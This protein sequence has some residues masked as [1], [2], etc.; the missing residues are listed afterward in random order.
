[1]NTGGNK[2]FKILLYS[3]N[4]NRKTAGK[5]QG[6]KEK[7][8]FH[9]NMKTGLQICNQIFYGQKATTWREQH[10]PGIARAVLL[11][12]QIYAMISSGRT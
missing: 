9:E 2:L 7:A 8:G 1:M 4:Q 10:S 11:D 5:K 12:Y 3:L 6:Q